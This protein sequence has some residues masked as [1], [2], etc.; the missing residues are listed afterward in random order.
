MH[1]PLVPGRSQLEQ[2]AVAKRGQN[3]RNDPAGISSNVQHTARN[4]PSVGA[5]SFDSDLHKTSPKHNTV[6]RHWMAQPASLQMPDK[7]SLPE[8]A[9]GGSSLY[10]V[11]PAGEGTGGQGQEQ[12]LFGQP[13]ARRRPVS[14]RRAV[15]NAGRSIMGQGT[16]SAGNSP[17]KQRPPAPAPHAP[18]SN[19]SKEG[20]SWGVFAGRALYDDAMVPSF[21]LLTLLLSPPHHH[22]VLSHIWHPPPLSL[23]VP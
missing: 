11:R 8:G 9:V 20:A 18:P 2:A 16:S 3:R 5:Q 23:L 7:R 4:N 10:G 21:T 22:C 19:P 1:V 14:G 13:S 17:V 12:H 6:Q 15:G